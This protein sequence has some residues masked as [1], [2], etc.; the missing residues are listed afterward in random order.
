MSKRIQKTDVFGDFQTPLELARIIWKALPVDRVQA[1]IEPTVGEGAF[2]EAAPTAM[3][4]V[5][6]CC[7]DINRNYVEKTTA[8]AD[9]LGVDRAAIQV[10]DAFSL[11]SEDFSGFQ[12]DEPVLAIGNPPWVT[13]SGQSSVHRSNLPEKNNRESGLRGLDALTGRANFDIAEAILLRLLAALAD[14]RDVRLAFLVKRSVAMRLAKR[15]FGRADELSFAHIEAARWFGASVDAGLF[16]AHV[17]RPSAGPPVT[18]INIA[19]EIGAA[20]ARRAGIANGGYVEDLEAHEAVSDLLADSTV[21]WRQGVKHDLARILEL[22]RLP[23]GRIV[24]GFDEEVEIERDVLAPLYKGSDVA[25]GRDPS[26]WFPL[27]QVNLGGPEPAMDSKWPKL[28]SYLRAHENA[29]QARRSRIYRGKHPYSLFG[30]GPYLLAPWKVAI[31]GLYRSARFSVLGPAGGRPALVDD[32][33]YLLPY[34]DRDSAHEVAEYLNSAGPQQLISSLSDLGAK[35]PFTKAV[36][37]RV[38]V[39]LAPLAERGAAQLALGAA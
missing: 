22:R 18:H 38:A 2:L 8:V 25:N 3:H 35:R 33:C 34:G 30:V 9:Q 24:N 39:P 12:L 14:F 31:C 10:A 5:R 16:C 27:Y 26:R 36:L 37:A 21:P 11:N 28:A 32:T 29:F 7:F 23:D 15:L 20:P 4:T 6:W 17:A 1:V 13:S 19:E